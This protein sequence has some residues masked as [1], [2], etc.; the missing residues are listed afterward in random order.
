MGGRVCVGILHVFVVT[1]LLASISLISTL[2]S[3]SPNTVTREPME[4]A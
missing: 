2:A 1:H 4:R 3:S